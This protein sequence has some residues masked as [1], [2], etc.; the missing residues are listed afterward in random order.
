MF[1]YEQAWSIVNYPAATPEQIYAVV[2]YYPQ[3]HAYALNH[4]NISGKSVAFMAKYALDP[5]VKQEANR[6]VAMLGGMAGA[7]AAGVVAGHSVAGAPSGEVQ[8]ANLAGNDMAVGPN[9]ASNDMAAGSNMPSNDM[10]AGPNVAGNDMA[11]GPNL[12]SNDM[13]AGPNMAADPHATANQVYGDQ[14]PTDAGSVQGAPSSSHTGVA[15]ATKKSRGLLSSTGSIVATSVVAVVVVAGIV[16]GAIIGVKHMGGSGGGTPADAHATITKITNFKL[17]E[18]LEGLHEVATDKYSNYIVNKETGEFF[19]VSGRGV[20]PA[21]I[22]ATKYVPKGKKDELVQG[23]FTVTTDYILYDSNDYS[24]DDFVGFVVFDMKAGKEVKI[25]KISEALREG[26]KFFCANRYL[27]LA[28]EDGSYGSIELHSGKLVVNQ[29]AGST[30]VTFGA[31]PA[32]KLFGP[33]GTGT[34]GDVSAYMVDAS[35]GKQIAL[36]KG[37]TMLLRDGYVTFHQNT[38][39]FELENVVVHDD[40]GKE[41]GSYPQANGGYIADSLPTAK[42]FN[43]AFEQFYKTDKDKVLAIDASGSWVLTDTSNKVDGYPM[44]TPIVSGD[45]AAYGIFDNGNQIVINDDSNYTVAVYKKGQNKPALEI[46]DSGYL[47]R[48]ASGFLVSKGGQ[49]YVLN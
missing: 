20:V 28:G 25:P 39:T 3:L 18:P 5:G 31:G 23:D 16:T 2:Y 24:K 42:D 1:T 8:A 32:G 19:L 49:L 40:S 21:S 11:A 22:D 48:I 34:G 47:R 41:L 43:K 37:Q 12:A 26:Q 4:P 6:R 38:S 44:F 15:T 13:T 10:A 46:K 33:M 29:P 14:V 9:M 35:N 17:G 30:V 36:P 27:F 7:M 45:N